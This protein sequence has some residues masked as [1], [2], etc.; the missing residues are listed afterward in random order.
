MN[1][2]LSHAEAATLATAIENYLPQLAET[3]ASIEHGWEAHEVWDMYRAL[4]AIR[5]RLTVALA[6]DAGAS[7]LDQP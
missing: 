3:A 5:S 4:E 6:T 1:L 7:A 2:V